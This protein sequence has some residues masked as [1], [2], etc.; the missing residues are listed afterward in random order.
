ME[1]NKKVKFSENSLKRNLEIQNCLLPNIE[2]ENN[3]LRE[4]NIEKD[5]NV[6]FNKYMTNAF[7]EGRGFKGILNEELDLRM[8]I[9]SRL[10]KKE[11]KDI[12]KYQVDENIDFKRVTC[13]LNL[14]RQGIDTRNVDKKYSE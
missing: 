13:N 4:Y 1:D 12:S 14:L 8:G 11:S 5:V 9:N 6:N 2:I 10:E 7:K 3:L